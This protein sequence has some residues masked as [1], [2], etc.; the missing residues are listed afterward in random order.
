MTR[1]RGVPAVATS[2]EG[3]TLT[4]RNSG[5]GRPPVNCYIGLATPPGIYDVPCRPHN[6]SR[7]TAQIQSEA[8]TG[9]FPAFS[10]LFL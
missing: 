3:P 5:R 9:T 10:L 4:A 8:I 1:F 7:M 6:N 2:A